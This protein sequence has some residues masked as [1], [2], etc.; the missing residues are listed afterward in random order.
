MFTVRLKIRC[1][2]ML[3]QQENLWKEHTLKYEFNIQI[4][5]TPLPT[6]GSGVYG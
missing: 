1:L 3:S 6:H 4:Y 2:K 5:E